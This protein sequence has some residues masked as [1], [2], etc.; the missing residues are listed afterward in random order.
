MVLKNHKSI[1][2]VLKIT[3]EISAIIMSVSVNKLFHLKQI[4]VIEVLCRNRFLRYSINKK[5]IQFKNT[6]QRPAVVI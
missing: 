6:L 2:V 5:K 1:L 3:T 4:H